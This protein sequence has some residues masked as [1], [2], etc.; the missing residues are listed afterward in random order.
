M[1]ENIVK[2]LEINMIDFRENKIELGIIPPDFKIND[3]SVEI[4]TIGD[5]F[6]VT[7][8]CQHVR[9]NADNVDLMIMELKGETPLMMTAEFIVPIS[10]QHKRKSYT[11]SPRLIAR[12]GEFFISKS[13][14]A[15]SAASYKVEAVEI[16]A[17]NQYFSN[18]NSKITYGGRYGY[19][20]DKGDKEK[21]LKILQKI[22]DFFNLL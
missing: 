16:E 21:I 14:K 9:V 11:S 19:M 20:L 18:N 13:N 6:L 15:Y 5:Q 2:I 17:E 12:A 8:G 1:K 22:S 10:D 4:S 3:R 7:V